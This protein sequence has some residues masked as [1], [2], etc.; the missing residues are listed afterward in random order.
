M[1]A[2]FSDPLFRD[3]VR[4]W[5]D[6]FGAWTGAGAW[7]GLHGHA[8]MGCLAALGSLAEVRGAAAPAVLIDAE[9][10]Y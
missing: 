8:L 10:P 2:P 4:L 7:Y 5:E 9:G 6:A 3:Y 1:G